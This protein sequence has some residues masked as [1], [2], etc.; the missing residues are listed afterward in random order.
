MSPYFLQWSHLRLRKW[1]VHPVC[2]ALYRDTC[3]DI[4][5]SI[6]V[7]GT[8]R[9]GTTWLSKIIGSQ[10]SCR[11]M[12]E[13]FHARYVPEFEGFQYFQYMRPEADDER[14]HTYCQRV[15]SG[16]I[17]N[18][19]ID[20]EVDVIRPQFRI[21]KEIRMN[22]FLK[23]FSLRFPEVP[24]LFVIRHPCAV[25]LSRMQWGWDST[26]DLASFM[27]QPAL[28]EDYLA[29][30]LEVIE[31]AR[32]EEQKH[33]LVWCISNLVPL[34][35][36]AGSELPVFLYERMVDRPE[37]EVPRLFNSIGQDYA[38]SVFKA[39]RRPSSSTP[40]DS[41]VMHGRPSASSWK[42]KLSRRK[43]DEIL[44]VVDAF[45][46]RYLYADDRP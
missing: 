32:T 9:S 1:L 10:L 37:R 28:L 20:R 29:D 34:R 39:L 12:F 40:A 41:A 7:A 43:I 27:A 4:G 44:A 30:K 15:L 16:R 33:A 14:L 21:V 3:P 25:V 19:W 13:P 8:G 6:V 11:V 31:G 36:F 5:R 35:Q 2:R 42:S 17:R 45:G 22:L 46:L 26:S 38:P 24:L 18:R 23:W